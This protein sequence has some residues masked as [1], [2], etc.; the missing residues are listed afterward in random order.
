MPKPFYHT[1]L[2]SINY[3][4]LPFTHLPYSFISNPINPSQYTYHSKPFISKKLKLFLARA[5][6][7]HVSHPYNTEGKHTFKQS[8]LYF[9]LNFSILPYFSQA[10]QHFDS[11]Y[12]SILYFFFCP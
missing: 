12:H 5:L 8:Y 11:L 7:I 2:R 9:F 6:I 3:T 10:P 1:L 4:L